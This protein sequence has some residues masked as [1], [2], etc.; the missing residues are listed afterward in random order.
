MQLQSLLALQYASIASSAVT[1]ASEGFSKDGHHGLFNSSH[2]LDSLSRGSAG[3]ILLFKMHVD[4]GTPPYPLERFVQLKIQSIHFKDSG[5]RPKYYHTKSF[6]FQRKGV[7]CRA[8]S[9][10]PPSCALPVMED[11]ACCPVCPSG[12]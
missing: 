9:C 12:G 4:S 8:E 3:R 10:P 5:F 1:A 2:T 6:S 7:R 11:G